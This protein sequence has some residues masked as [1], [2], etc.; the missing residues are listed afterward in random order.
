MR[1]RVRAGAP[2]ELVRRLVQ[3]D[4]INVELDENAN[5][6]NIQTA[7]TTSDR[8]PNAC[9]SSGSTMQVNTFSILNL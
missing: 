3:F 9:S 8:W 6:G 4:E 7:V 2:Q 5:L 1:F